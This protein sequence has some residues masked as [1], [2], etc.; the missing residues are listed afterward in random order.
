[1]KVLITGSGGNLGCE[2]VRAFGLAGHDVS[3]CERDIL[4]ITD[5]QAV[6]EA[7]LT[8]GYD[9]VI[10]AAAFNDVDGMEKPEIAAKAMGINVHGP[11]NL[12]VACR[13]VRI[14]FV[15]Y[16]TDYVFDGM[17]TE[18]YDE[19]S[20]PAPLSAYGRSKLLGER[21]ALMAHPGAYVLRTSKLFGPSGHTAGSKPSFAATMLRLAIEKPELS[22]VHDEV[23]CPTYTVDLAQTTVDLLEGEHDPG[24]YHI[25]NSGP[26]VTWYEFAEEIFGLANVATPRKPVPATPRPAARPKHAVL[27]NT[28]FPPLR[29]RIEAL[30]DYLGQP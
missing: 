21:G 14:P 27:L 30:R 12:A 18:G 17:R 29:P 8:G 25:V 5:S 16:S 2:L 24:I 26:G 23:G 22:I 3:P 4:D 11:S 1:M 20:E 10:N 15:H 9:A 28:K 6:F 13:A 7:I 19:A